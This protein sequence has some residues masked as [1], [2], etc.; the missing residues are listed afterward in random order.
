MRRIAACLLIL[1]CAAGEALEAQEA[2]RAYTEAPRL[3]LRP[4]RL[5]LLKRERERQSIRFQQ[6]DAYI[7]NDQYVPENGFAYS[8]AGKVYENKEHCAAAANWL[9]KPKN[10][11]LRQRALSLDWCAEMLP[12]ASVAALRKSVEAETPA[13]SGIASLRDRVFAALALTDVKADWSEKIA[14]ESVEHWK[15][16][17]APG[18]ANGRPVAKKELYPLLELLHA[19]RDNYDID[20]RT[21]AAQY[22]LDLPLVQMLSYYPAPYPGKDNEFRVSFFANDGDPDLNLAV[23]ERAAELSLV[24]FDNN[25]E[26]SQPLQGW[27]LQD[28]Y[29]MR[30][31]EGIPYEFLWANPYQPGLTYHH[32][33]NSF[34]DKANGRLLLRG[35]WEEEA[36]YMCYFD[37]KLQLFEDGVRKMVKLSS[38]SEPVEIGEA[39]LIVGTKEMLKPLQFA[40]RGEPRE[41]WY[42]VGLKANTVYDIEMDDNELREARTD[43]GGIL[44]LDFVKEAPGVGVRLRESAYAKGAS[45]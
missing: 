24:S 13:P 4:Q 20:L 42:V 12:P 30:G 3:L 34:H 28:R 39:T 8:L 17:I 38:A 11:D 36:R 1:L 5:R 2:Y 21:D 32:L 45:E 7:S 22:F 6:F 25:A 33:P 19:V 10:G 9:L 15:K 40:L 35:G 43:A 37:G 44:S 29:L 31:P 18:I 41:S 27:L 16:A 26:L 23:M 14:K